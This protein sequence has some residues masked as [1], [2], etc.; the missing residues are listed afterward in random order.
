[1]LVSIA[2]YCM[3]RALN[4]VE[5]KY[6]GEIIEMNQSGVNFYSDSQHNICDNRMVE[7]YIR[8]VTV[9][10]INSQDLSFVRE[11]LDFVKCR[12]LPFFYL[13][14]PSWFSL[15]PLLFNEYNANKISTFADYVLPEGYRVRPLHENDKIYELKS[16][17]QYLAE[18]FL[19]AEEMKGRPN[20][21]ALFRVIV[22]EKG[23]LGGKIYAYI[24]EGHIIA[25]L[26]CYIFQNNIYDIDHVYVLPDY[27]RQGIGLQL[28]KYYINN[29]II[30]GGIPRYGNA[31]NEYSRSLA[32]KAGFIE[33]KCQDKYELKRIIHE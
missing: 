18:N 30:M 6:C 15:P 1:M 20:F 24:K 7:Y 22:Q 9:Y 3:I 33:I 2:K 12:T 28:V 14:V 31:E 27:R 21:N 4:N 16:T 8:N 29:T 5:I 23:L 26:S 13:F 25:Y 10:D 11:C 17:D 19:L 32:K